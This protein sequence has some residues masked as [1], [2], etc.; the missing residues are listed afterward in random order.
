MSLMLKPLEIQV[1]VI[2]GATSG[3][4]LVTARMAAKRRARLVLAARSEDVL[5][6]LAEEIKSAGGEAT[7]VVADVGNEADVLKIAATAK[8]R[9]GG[10]D[11]WITTPASRSMKITEVPIAEHGGSLIQLLGVVHGSLAA[12]I[13]CDNAAG[14]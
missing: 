4:G 11:T 13:N 14:R 12:V 6:E 8:E 2:T 9:F 7:Y 5:Q 1:I 10:F 3:I